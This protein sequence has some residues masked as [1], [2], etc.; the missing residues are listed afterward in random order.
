MT[1]FT[2]L[3]SIVALMQWIAAIALVP[4][5]CWQLCRNHSSLCRWISLLS[6]YGVQ[7]GFYLLLDDVG[8]EPDRLILLASAAAY[9]WVITSLSLLPVKR[10]TINPD[11]KLDSEATVLAE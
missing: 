6:G 7:V 1:I 11:A 3:L 10:R 2:E 8:F 4:L 9:F 5:A